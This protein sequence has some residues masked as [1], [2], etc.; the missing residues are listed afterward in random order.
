MGGSQQLILPQ[1]VCP[2]V[3]GLQEGVP[4]GQLPGLTLACPSWG[5]HVP[6]EQLGHEAVGLLT[7]PCS[8]WLAK[9]GPDEMRMLPLDR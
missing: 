6:A 7:R 4:Q 8:W 2:R 9:P 3:W 5:W 1:G